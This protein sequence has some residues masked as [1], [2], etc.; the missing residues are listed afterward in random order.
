MPVLLGIGLF[1]VAYTKKI[2]RLLDNRPFKWMAKVSY[3][4]YLYHALVIGIMRFT[5]FTGESVPM[6]QWLVLVA[7]TFP[8]AFLLAHFS[9]QYVEMKAVIWY[10]NRK[11]KKS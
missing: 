4:V 9:N 5:V 2:G 8:V 11:S 10:R 6:P 3:S 1:T 7:I